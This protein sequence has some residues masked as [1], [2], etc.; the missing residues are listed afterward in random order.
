VAVAATVDIVNQ[1]VV[2]A[3][4]TAAAAAAAGGL[5]PG[6]P[7]HDMKSL[8]AAAGTSTRSDFSST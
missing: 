1:I 8:P 7:P 6:L 2:Q 4:D 3:D 5:A